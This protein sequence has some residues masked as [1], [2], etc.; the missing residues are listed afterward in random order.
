MKTP[1]HHNSRNR[2]QHARAAVAPRHERAGALADLYAEGDPAE[3]AS[4][5]LLMGVGAAAWTDPE[6]GLPPE[7][8]IL[9]L[10]E[11]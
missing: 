1:S 10:E 8:D 5:E 7:V 4:D 6:T 3:D 2:H 11:G 9:H